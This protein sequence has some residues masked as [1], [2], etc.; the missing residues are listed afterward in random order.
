[1]VKS[2]SEISADMIKM[3]LLAKNLKEINEKR[4]NKDLSL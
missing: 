4:S 2:L 1:V 3:E